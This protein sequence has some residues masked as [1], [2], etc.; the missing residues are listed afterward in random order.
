MAMSHSH[1]LIDQVDST[2]Y[3]RLKGFVERFEDAWQQGQRPALKEFLPAGGPDRWLVLIELIHIDLEL[4]LKAGETARAEDYLQRYPELA[5]DLGVVAGLVWAEFELRRRCQPGLA[6]D[7]Y[8]QRFPHC[9]DELLSRLKACGPPPDLPAPALGPGTVSPVTEGDTVGPQ[10]GMGAAPA[11]APPD[12]PQFPGYE[13]LE[14]IGRGGMG[15]VYKARHR[16][17][18]RLAAIKVPL[19]GLLAEDAERERFLREARAAAGLRHP[20]IC[21]IYEV[22]QHQGQPFIAMGFI[23]G[24]DLRAW[25][26][27]QRPSP[28]QAAEVVAGLAR[29]VGY[30]HDHGVIHRDIKPANVMVDAETGQPVLMDFGLAK[31]LTGEGSKLTQT[32]QVMG[33]PAYMAPEQAAGQLEGV[34]PAADVY[35][36]GAV[37]YELLCGCPPFQGSVG[38][39]LRRV[40]TE[41]PVPPR[42]LT[43]R[44]HRDLETICLKALAKDPARRYATAIALAEDLERF[45]SGEAILARREGLAGKVWRT[46]RRRPVTY[47]SILAACLGVAVAGTIAWRADRDRRVADLQSRLEAG[48]DAGDWS[49]NHLA[50]LD[51]QIADLARLAPEQAVAVRRRLHQRFADAIRASIRTSRVLPKEIATIEAALKRLQARDPEQV[52]ALRQAINQHIGK[53]IEETLRLPR[54]TP[55]DVARLET[56]LRLLAI[57]DPARVPAL[58]QAAAQRLR[59]WET[60]FELKAPFT[61]LKEVLDAPGLRVGAKGLAFPAPPAPAPLPITTVLTRFPCQGNAQLEVEMDDSWRDASEIRLLL[62]AAPTHFRRITALAFAL[63]SQTLATASQ[64]ATVKLWDTTTGELKHTLAEP[65]GPVYCLAFLKDGHT[66]VT[67]TEKWVRFWDEAR[68]KQTATFEAHKGSVLSLAVSPNGKRLATGGSDKTAKVWDVGAHTLLTTLTGHKDAVTLVGFH[69]GNSSLVTITAGKDRT[70][71]VWNL[72]TGSHRDFTAS[73]FSGYNFVA[74]SADG[75]TLAGSWAGSAP[76]RLKLWDVAQGKERASFGIGYSV[77][78]FS[79]DGKTLAQGQEDLNSQPIALWDVA[80]GPVRS[81]LRTSFGDIACLAFSPDGATLA[82]AGTD[83][84]L[85]LWNVARRSQRRSLGGQGYTF[86]LTAPGLT[87][88]GPSARAAAAAGPEKGNVRLKSSGRSQNGDRTPQTKSPVPVSRPPSSRTVRL[89]IVRDGVLLREQEATL[90]GATKTLRLRCSRESGSLKFHVNDLPAV[91]FQDMFALTGQATGKFGLSWPAGVRLMQVRASRQAL[92]AAGSPLERGDDFFGQ[93]R[94]HRALAFY[95]EQALLSGN[96]E[97]GREAHCKAA[98]CLLGLGR[99]DEAG[100]LFEQVANDPAGGRWPLAAA[101]HLWLLRLGQNR[102]DDPETDALIETVFTRYRLEEVAA[103]IPGYVRQQIVQAYQVGSVDYLFFK[104]SHLRKFQRAVTVCD[105]FQAPWKQSMRLKMGLLHGYRLLGRRKEALATARGIFKYFKETPGTHLSVGAGHVFAECCW[106]LRSHGDFA[107]LQDEIDRLPGLGGEGSG[108][109]DPPPLAFSYPLLLER[110]RLHGA[111]KKWAEAEKDLDSFFKLPVVPD[112]RL[113]GHF[114]EA[115][116]L[117][118]FLCE[119]RGAGEQA[120]RWWRRGL[121]PAWRRQFPAA[122]QAEL[123]PSDQKAAVDYLILG[124]LTNELTDAEVRACMDRL[125]ATASADSPVMKMLRAF[126]LPAAAYREAWRSFRGR[127]FAKKFAYRDLSFT[128]FVR[129]PAFLVLA[130]TLHQGALPGPLSKD[131]DDLLWKLVQDAFTAYAE[132]R[133]NPVQYLQLGITWKGSS[134]SFGWGAVSGSLKPSLRGPLAYLFGHRYL[135]LK[136]KEE[137]A[138]FFRTAL[139]DAPP[140]SSLKRLA[141]PQ[142]DHLKAK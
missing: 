2:D 135:R 66:L 4:R 51:G 29:A 53:F 131:Q 122:A 73:F 78:A 95:R 6:L 140:N 102:F 3:V 92:P 130:E 47:L 65:A 28:R 108:G 50:Q 26:A 111:R 63:D 112:A 91:V 104:E 133:L 124:S 128:D 126:P 16:L 48:L 59:D 56:A 57:R 132:G 141:Q 42:R 55:E 40:Q 35:S 33:T 81:T 38:E 39:V 7:E 118:G 64:D 24:E 93:G 129:V 115:C 27:R 17:L 61:N 23:H 114:A 107:W 18:Q 110:A 20:L 11:A 62:N 22:G 137:A 77:L 82:S 70:V 12:L 119:R 74:L 72:A 105:L 113:Y 60:V 67:G 94:F 41:E 9:R 21:P 97:V 142:L 139:A 117:R 43:P 98:L 121:F 125:L 84:A 75:R 138:M 99:P 101:C 103:L 30:A 44:L 120:L 34:G 106:V 79:P 68:G 69:A 83:G 31:E 80:S 49:A 25:I 134:G 87:M 8:V 19:P 15:K 58:R 90:P 54:L 109:V 88:A 136:K 116:L 71:S 36:L 127:Q 89:R 1:A 14:V 10:P 52:P 46:V 13:V 123:S 85:K 100:P 76:G 86:V 5:A 96:A 32:G 37:L 45:Y